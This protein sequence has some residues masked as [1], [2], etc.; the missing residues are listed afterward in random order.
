[1]IL[2]RL[3]LHEGPDNTVVASF[4]LPGLKK[5]DVSIELHNNQLTISGEAKA[6]S[7][8]SSSEGAQGESPSAK[9]FV[10]ERRFGSFSRTV[11]LPEG[12]QPES[13][14]ATVADGVLTVT[15][16][17]STPEQSP[18]KITIQ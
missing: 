10:R 17:K 11:Q 14:K 6:T 18:K 7:S 1:M 5:E 15:Y 13:V 8:T 2:S 16:P 12:T 3:D 4:E 9:Y